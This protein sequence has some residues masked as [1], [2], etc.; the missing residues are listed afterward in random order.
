MLTITFICLGNICRSPMAEALMR[1]KVAEAGLSDKIQVDSVG[2]GNWHVGER[3]HRG[4]AKVLKYHD[5]DFKGITARQLN[6][7]DI[8]ESD[9]LVVMD[10]DNYNDVQRMANRDTG[11][12]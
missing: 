9:Y 8:E 10:L 7:R 6:E 12:G 1:H 4:T 2:T 5:I 11:G 3:P